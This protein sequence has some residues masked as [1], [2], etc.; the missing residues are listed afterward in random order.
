MKFGGNKLHFGDKL[1]TFNIL[2]DFEFRPST[3]SRMV[4]YRLTVVE[5]ATMG[6]AALEREAPW[7]LGVEREENTGDFGDEYGRG[8]ESREKLIFV[9]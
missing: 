6:V 4:G 2:Y 8:R 7:G 5:E 9:F 1:T 3:S